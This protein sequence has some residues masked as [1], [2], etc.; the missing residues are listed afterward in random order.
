MKN[1]KSC[2]LFLIFLVSLELQMCKR[3]F[4]KSSFMFRYNDKQLFAM[5]HEH[6]IMSGC[7]KTAESLRNEIEITPLVDPGQFRS[8]Y[9]IMNNYSGSIPFLT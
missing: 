7:F 6:L 5:I 1:A 8:G 9:F 3:L 2:H 4:F